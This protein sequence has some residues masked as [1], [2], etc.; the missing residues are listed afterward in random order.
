MSTHTDGNLA[1]SPL[2]RGTN[3]TAL[4]KE[5]RSLHVAHP[6]VPIRGRGTPDEKI[7]ILDIVREPHRLM[8]VAEKEARIEVEQGKKKL[9]EAQALKARIDAGNK[10]KAQ[11]EK[12]ARKRKQ[13]EED[14]MLTATCVPIYCEIG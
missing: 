10:T 12:E 9:A 1:L 2:P 5:V 8:T 13:F 7:R 4:E 3:T 6:R 11:L 14:L